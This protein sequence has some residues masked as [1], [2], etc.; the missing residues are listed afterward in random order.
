M[1]PGVGWQWS[2]RPVPLGPGTY[3][4]RELEGSSF[5]IL[6]FMA[7]DDRGDHSKVFDSFKAICSL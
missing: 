6:Q 5:G 4:E 7:M 1:V 3:S 2:W